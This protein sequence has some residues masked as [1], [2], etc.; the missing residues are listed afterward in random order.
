MIQN[1]LKFVAASL[2]LVLIGCRGA[3]P[4]Y[5]VGESPVVTNKAATTEAVQQAITRAGTSLG[6]QMIAREPGRMEGILLLR[7]HRAVVDIVYDTK[8]YSIQYKDSSNLNY[9]ASANTIHGNYNGWIQ[10]LDRAI[11]AQL[12]AL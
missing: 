8:N 11:R 5:N 6:W 7:R 3:V 2:L 1:V 4:I 9:D 10:N 12:S